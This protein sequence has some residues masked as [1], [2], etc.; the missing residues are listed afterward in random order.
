MLEKIPHDLL[1][2]WQAQPLEWKVDRSL[3]RIKQFYE[4]LDGKVYVSFSGGKDSTALLYLVRSIY[5]NIPAVHVNTGLE[6]PEI[7]EFVKTVDNVII[8]RPKKSFLEVI[9]TWG[10]PVVSKEVSMDISRYRG[11]K[12]PKMKR[13]RLSG[14]HPDGRCG[15]HMGVIPKRWQYLV[16]APF[17]I[18]DYCCSVMKKEPF[19]RFQRETGLF[20]FI[21]TMASDSERRKRDFLNTGCNTFGK[22]ALSTPMAFWLEEDVWEYL[23]RNNIPYCKIYDM[24]ERRTGCMFCMFGVHL[25]ENPNRFRR[26]KTS[27]PQLWNYCMYKLGLFKV[28]EYMG[29]DSGVDSLEKF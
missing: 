13:F 25:E 22:R 28:L 27:H 5:P 24:G 7:E 18:S 10:Y 20:P 29:I 19:H 8:I 3:L 2:E 14:N 9:N 21:G 23:R 11:T 17:K 16:D 4:K 15:L 6:Y 1:K 12:D 26:M